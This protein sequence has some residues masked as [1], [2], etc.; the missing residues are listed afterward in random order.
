VA[1]EY[2][3]QRYNPG[4]TTFKPS[5][6]GGTNYAIGGATTGFDNYNQFNPI[7]PGPLQPSFAALGL[8][9]QLGQ[10]Q[11]FV[12]GGGTFNPATSLFVV[13][14]F[15]NDVFWGLGSGQLPDQP[16]VPATPA[17]LITQGIGNIGN[18]I[19]FLAGLGGQHF[20]VPNMPDLGQTPLGLGLTPEESTGLTM[21]TEGFNTNLKFALTALDDLLPAAEI[22]L[23]DTFGT[24]Q[25]VTEN[26][27]AFGFTDATRACIKSPAECNPD[28]WVFWDEVH[29][30]TAAHRV[31][32]TM[33]AAA[34]PEPSSLALLATVLLL[35][36]VARRRGARRAHRLSPDRPH[37]RS[38]ASWRSWMRESRSCEETA[39]SRQRNMSHCVSHSSP[40]VPR[41]AD[42]PSPS[43]TATH[44]STNS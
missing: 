18:A 22:V 25:A 42:A 27:G 19:A 9:P 23:F 16:G 38:R 7:V 40:C 29:P 35:G 21:L 20:L 13:W 3:W 37:G 36:M 41:N 10:F 12:T 8:T 26:P 43:S 32:G 4:S 15:P 24:L 14:A 30:T 17:A 33:F 28:T 6:G 5:L 34:V 2:L 31:L 44:H 11:A 39:P 1:V